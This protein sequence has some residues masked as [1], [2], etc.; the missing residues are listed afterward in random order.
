MRH[1]VSGTTPGA[2]NGRWVLFSCI[3]AGWLNLACGRLGG[4]GGRRLFLLHFGQGQLV[5][6][7]GGQA[8][9]GCQ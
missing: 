5:G 4:G 3:A 8:G 9:V 7:D 6:R 1:P 2:G